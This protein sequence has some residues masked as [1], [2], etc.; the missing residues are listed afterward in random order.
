MIVGFTG[1]RRGMSASQ[2]HQLQRVLDWLEASESEIG[3]GALF[4][5]GNAPGADAE[6]SRIAEARG[7]EVVSHPAGANPLVRNREIV[8][9]C[10]VLVAAPLTDE[11]VLR[12]GTWATVRYARAAG[13]PV[14]FLSNGSS[15]YYQ[16]R[17]PDRVPGVLGRDANG[18][19]GDR[20]GRSTNDVAQ[21]VCPECW[22]A[23]RTVTGATVAVG[24][25]DR[26]DLSM[27]DRLR[28]CSAGHHHPALGYAVRVGAP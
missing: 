14:I 20:G 19:R 13:K 9:A 12:S 3:G 2:E 24:E 15:N 16:R 7:W 10:E 17:G 22:A 27:M 18:Y 6:A 4:H 25:L 8:A 23:T 11:E 21:I 28:T 26:R 1:T 5:H